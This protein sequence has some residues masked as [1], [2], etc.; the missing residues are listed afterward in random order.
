VWENH[1]AYYYPQRAVRA[2]KMVIHVFPPLVV[3]ADL[4]VKKRCIWRI[5]AVIFTK[6]KREQREGASG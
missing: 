4:F 5:E 6:R 2:V 3:L 1:L